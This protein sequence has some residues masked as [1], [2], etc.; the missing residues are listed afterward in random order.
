MILYHPT[1]AAFPLTPDLWR[2]ALTLA[3]Q[4]GWQPAGTLPPAASLE[5]GP[6]AWPAA[7]EPASGQQVTRPDARALA[8]ALERALAALPD[9]ALP[10][11]QLARFCHEG[12]FLVCP[13]PGVVD[14]LLNLAHYASAAG[15][16]APAHPDPRL[17][18][19]VAAEPQGPAAA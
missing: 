12:G 6:D 9:P 3:H 14:S 1:G 11:R 17:P 8:S 7:Y 10:L 18:S 13:S 4:H 2:S 5:H 16:S 19:R 15:A